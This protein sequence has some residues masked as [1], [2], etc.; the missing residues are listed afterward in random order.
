[1]SRTNVI[2]ASKTDEKSYMALSSLVHA[3]YEAES[4]GIARFVSKDG[5]NP[6]ILLL[7]PSIEPNLECLIDIELPFAEDVRSYKFPSLDKIITVSGKVLT[8]HRNLPSD[9]LKQAM[10][11]YVDQMDLST[12]GRDE[13][14]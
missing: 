4:F 2:I 12:L 14:G 1:M 7:A 10:S 9:Q 5:R 13:D 11:D 3:L 8:Q 6:V